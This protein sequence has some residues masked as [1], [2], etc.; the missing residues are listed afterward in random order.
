[1]KLRD[2]YATSAEEIAGQSKSGGVDQAER[3]AYSIKGVAGNAGASSLQE[4]AVELEHA[5][6][7]GEADT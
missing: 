7:E 3:L 4:A 5:I 2:D 1:M 6:K